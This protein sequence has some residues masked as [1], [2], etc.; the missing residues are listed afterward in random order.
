MN[1]Y[2]GN[3]IDEILIDDYN[4]ELSDDYI[5]LLYKLLKTQGISNFI[6]FSI[7]P[8]DDVVIPHDIL[9]QFISE[10]EFINNILEFWLDNERKVEIIE[11]VENIIKISKNAVAQK[12]GLVSIGD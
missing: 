7:D 6:L 11:I 3:T 1:F 8:Y 4:V 9:F 2:I 5:D 12:R 10:C